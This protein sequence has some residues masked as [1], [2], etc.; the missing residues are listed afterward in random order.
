MPHVVQFTTPSGNIRCT[1]TPKLPAALMCSIERYSFG[2]P[3]RPAGCHL[4]WSTSLLDLTSAGA[5]LGQ[6]VAGPQVTV[7][8]HVL[9]YGDVLR[10]QGFSCYSGGTALTCVEGKT[11]HGFRVSRDALLRF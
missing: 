7:A 11:G 6:C 2:P 1:L 4:N 5:A 10:A 8:S 9:D 3:S